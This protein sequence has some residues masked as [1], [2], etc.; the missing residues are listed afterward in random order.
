MHIFLYTR[1]E[2]LFVV[3]WS[4]APAVVNAFYSATKNQISK[5]FGGKIAWLG[6]VERGGD[7]N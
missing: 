4:T 1:S 6:V 7:G 2:L 5:Y 3:R